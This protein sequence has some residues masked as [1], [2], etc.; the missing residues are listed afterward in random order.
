[1]STFTQAHND[2]LDPELAAGKP[3]RPNRSNKY[4]LFTKRTD[5]PKL[6]WLEKR[7]AEAGIK[8]RRNGESCHA[9][10]LE[11]KSKDLE[12]AWDILSPIDDIEDDDPRWNE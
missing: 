10:I 9:P 1:M 3:S 7:L 11:V 4:V 6:A 2:Y 12:A 5:D 8:S